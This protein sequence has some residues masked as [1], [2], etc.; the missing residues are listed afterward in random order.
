MSFHEKIEEKSYTP[1]PEDFS[2]RKRGLSFNEISDNSNNS[3]SPNLKQDRNWIEEIDKLR[4][5]SLSKS[6]SNS[7]VNFI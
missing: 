5:K 6:Q 2:R 1:S 3:K 7:N 4:N